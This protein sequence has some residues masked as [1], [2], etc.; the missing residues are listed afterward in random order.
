M[1]EITLEANAK[2]AAETWDI[3]IWAVDASGN[4]VATIPILKD[5][6]QIIFVRH[7]KMLHRVRISDWEKPTRHNGKER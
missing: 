1:F 7:G 6:R 2:D 3:E 5:M 4:V